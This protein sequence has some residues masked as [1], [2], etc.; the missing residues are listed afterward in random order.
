MDLGDLRRR[1]KL[2]EDKHTAGAKSTENNEQ[3]ADAKSRGETKPL[4]GNLLEQECER[5]IYRVTYVE[6]EKD[7]IFCAVMI[8]ARGE[9]D[10][11]SV[12]LNKF[13]NKE[14]L[15]IRQL[16][17]VEVETNK[18]KG[19]SLLEDM[20][21]IEIAGI[22][23]SGDDDFKGTQ[24]EVTPEEKIQN[25]GLETII[26][27]L[28]QSTW[29]RVQEFKD[30]YTTFVT[31]E[32]EYEHKDDIIQELENL[33]VAETANIGTLEKILTLIDPKVEVIDK[34]KEATIQE[35]SAQGVETI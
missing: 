20:I 4:E 26:R 31:D 32:V 29:S 30:A 17:N 8:N 33:Q 1:Q 12:F 34:A 22:D 24:L 25:N 3:P 19:M 35:P 21:P 23:L 9:A 18:K 15:G 10:A 7:N 5:A 28:I 16:D 14:I 13:P 27:N 6:D 11:Q 2:Y